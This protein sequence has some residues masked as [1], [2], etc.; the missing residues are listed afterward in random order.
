M[1]STSKGKHSEGAGRRSATRGT[2]GSGG[3]QRSFS[4][5]GKIGWKLLTRKN[6]GGWDSPRG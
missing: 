1:P 4:I 5:I 2:P 3:I 6:K